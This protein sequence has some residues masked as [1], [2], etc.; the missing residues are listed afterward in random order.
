M[1]RLTAL[2]I[3]SRDDVHVEVFGSDSKYGFWITLGE[4]HRPLLT[5]NADWKSSEDAQGAG[6]QLLHDIRTL[7]LVE[8]EATR[9]LAPG[10]S[11][12]SDA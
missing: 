8:D 12:E 10:A 3:Q 6:I 5:S 4:Y 1:T 9:P 7:P 11:S 2:I